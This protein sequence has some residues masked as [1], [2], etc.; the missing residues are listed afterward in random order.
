MHLWIENRWQGEL[1]EEKQGVAP[2]GS[3]QL[4]QNVGDVEYAS[5]FI[6]LKGMLSNKTNKQTPQTGWH[7]QYKFIDLRS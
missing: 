5:S 6:S 4:L 2:L 1:P 3:G 7:G